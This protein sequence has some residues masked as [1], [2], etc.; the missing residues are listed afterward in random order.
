MNGVDEDTLM[1]NNDGVTVFEDDLDDII[2]E[3]SACL[4]HPEFEQVFEVSGLEVAASYAIASNCIDKLSNTGDDDWL[5]EVVR[6]A[7]NGLS[8]EAQAK[9]AEQGF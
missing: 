3:L 1:G 4:E 8:S 5:M 2:D 6:K 9:F 7:Y